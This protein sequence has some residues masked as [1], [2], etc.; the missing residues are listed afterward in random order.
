M[1][2]ALPGSALSG[3]VF[4][5][6]GSAVCGVGAFGGFSVDDLQAVADKACAVAGKSGS[7]GQ[8]AC[9]IAQDALKGAAVGSMVP[10]IGTTVGAAGAAVISF[11]ENVISPG[12]CGGG[13]V[14]VPPDD[15]AS[16][17]VPVMN[18]M[19]KL[20]V[21]ILNQPDDQ[22]CDV[23]AFTQMRNNLY[24][25][26]MASWR[27]LSYPQ[28]VAATAEGMLVVDDPPLEGSPTW[29]TNPGALIP[30]PKAPTGP[31]PA[32]LAA[33]AALRDAAA[34]QAALV[35][36]A[37]AAGDSVAASQAAARA[38]NLTLLAGMHSGGAIS[39]DG[40]AIVKPPSHAGLIVGTLLVAAAAGGFV[41]YK[42]GRKKK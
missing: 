11:V 34:Q 6:E 38:K 5:D 20:D 29:L 19:F 24:E 12:D 25:S 23:D 28:Q 30:R 35:G 2:G 32:Q 8:K 39:K 33:A 13:T 36:Q 4:G 42:Y 7:A 22:R 9:K 3:D 27:A 21:Q 16:F 10:L 31:T 14:Y 1:Y 17:P 40:T 37:T 18:E 26:L 15:R 41:Y